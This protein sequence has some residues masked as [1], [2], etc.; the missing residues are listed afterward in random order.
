LA[1]LIYF[2][3][4]DHH[5]IQ[6]FEAASIMRKAS[7]I[8]LF[9]A[10]LTA[11]LAAA[12]A[13][14]QD[15]IAD[16]YKGKTMRIIIGYGPG[17]G[18]DIYG[19]LFAEF[20][21]RYV[22][23]NPTIVAQNMAGA[24]SFLAA[25]Y[26]YNVAPQDGTSFG[27]LAQTLPLDYAMGAEQ[28]DLD[29]SKMPY[30]GR[31]VSNVDL[32]SGVPGATFKDIADARQRELVVGATGAASPGY[33]LPMALNAYGG[34]KFKVIY[35]YKGSNDVLLAAERK[36]V[37][38]IGSI[39]IATMLVRNPDWLLEKKAPMIYQAALTRHP[40]A[41]H[42]PALP[43]LASSADGKAV[44]T[45]IAASAD[46]GRAI[47][48][49]PNVPA[50]RVAALRKAFNA[51]VADPVFLEAMKKRNV[52]IEA[53]TGEQVDKISNDTLQTPKATL[54]LVQKLVTVK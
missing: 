13:Q 5:Y 46:I 38:I 22:P 7:V 17:G 41:Q 9:S 42:V 16:F 35:G 15:P 33:L 50:D 51:M 24:G 45:A 18:Y 31:L 54:N 39:G 2:G 37:D 23:G 26:L 3:R 52:T 19:R 28:K 44:L 20:F 11:G 30:I 43:E 10:F 49:T 1:R 36:E 12:P 6:S 53:L 32:G 29:A 8:T 48:T 34:T 21:G 40:L 47:V 27:S 4:R 14:A 25:K